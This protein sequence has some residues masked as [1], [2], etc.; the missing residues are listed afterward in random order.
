[1]TGLPVAAVAPP[2]SRQ[3]RAGV[4]TTIAVTER[5]GRVRRSRT[6]CLPLGKDSHRGLS[7]TDS[8][9]RAGQAKGRRHTAGGGLRRRTAAEPTPVFVV[10]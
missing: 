3:H 9:L 8:D 10:D 2:R 1:M 5:D 4:M 7:Q 6:Q